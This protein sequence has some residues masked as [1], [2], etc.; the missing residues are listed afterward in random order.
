MAFT[1]YQSA[2]PGFIA[3]LT[4]FKTWLDKAAAQKDEA[5][6][7]EARLAPDMFPLARQIQI[8][9]DGAKGAAARLTGI[10]A[11]AMPDTETSFAELKARCDKTIAYLQSVDPAAFDAGESREVVLTFPNGGGMRFDGATFLTGFAV[12]NFYFH[13]T[14]TY[15]ILRAQG[16]ELGKADFLMHLA[17]HMF[18]PPAA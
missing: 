4:N 16:V 17:P 13:A 7:L 10:E 18:A 5:D 1:L 6:L 2:V 11:P 12:P 8:A 9:S 14:A 3:M 15:A